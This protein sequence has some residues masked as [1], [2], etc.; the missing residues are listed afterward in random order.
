LQN[1]SFLFQTTAQT[2]SAEE[3]KLI[4]AEIAMLSNRPR[5][6]NMLMNTKP[7]QQEQEMQQ[8]QI[9]MQKAELEKINAEIENIKARAGENEI[10][11]RLKTAKAMNEETKAKLNVSNADKVDAEFIQTVKETKQGGN[12]KAKDK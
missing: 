7:T 12:N 4:Q 6:A 2:A 8:L 1:L 3:R 9:A 5:L 10:D 11:Q